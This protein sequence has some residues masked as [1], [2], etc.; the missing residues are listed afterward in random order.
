MNMTEHQPNSRRTPRRYTRHST[1]RRHIFRPPAHPGRLIAV[2]LAAVLVIASALVWGN[3]LKRQS[4]AHRADEE[5]G[6]WTLPPADTSEVS[7]ASPADRAYEIIPEGNVGDIVLA[8][9]HGGVLFPLR[10]ADG[11]L[12][13]RSAVAVEAGIPLPEDAPSLAD[14]VARVNRR[15]LRATGIFHITCFGAD[16]LSVQTYLRGLELALLCEYAS[17]GI[18][19]ILLIGL[20]CGNDADDALAVAFL[21]E[22]RGLLNTLAEPPA[23]GAALP[24]SAFEGEED[25]DGEPLYAGDISP[26]RIARVS[27][28]LAL[29]L[30]NK[31]LSQIDVLLPR[32]SYAY[33]RHTLHMMVSQYDTAATEDLLSHG[34]VRVFEM[35]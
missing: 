15:P 8:G 22:L 34:F 29:D 6:L 28:Y 17:S 33:T 7:P 4:D 14:D 10:D 5:N 32:L 11:G 9:K 26:A 2:I 27:D 20:P 13:Y 16:D 3:A 31:P 30:R 23:I 24:L 21:E 12:Y 1:K 35:T 25:E 18:D 19:D